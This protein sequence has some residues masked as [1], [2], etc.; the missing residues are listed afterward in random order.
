MWRVPPPGRPKNLER[1]RRPAILISRSMNGRPGTGSF[2]TVRGPQDNPSEVTLQTVFC[3]EG[4]GE[5]IM[6]FATEH[7]TD[8][9]A[10]AWRGRLNPQSLQHTQHHSTGAV[11]GIDLPGPRT[12]NNEDEILT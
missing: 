8:L 6:R 11:S 7:E 3:T 4:I 12:L 2:S 9:I 5:A 10:L 1:L